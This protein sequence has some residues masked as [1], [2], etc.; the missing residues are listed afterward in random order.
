PWK[1]LGWKLTNAVVQPQKL[2]LHSQLQTLNDMQKF[3]GDLQWL[4]PIV[5]IP[6][7]LLA[8]L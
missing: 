4:R 8:Q 7:E 1:Y 2:S 6:T 3:M 5:G